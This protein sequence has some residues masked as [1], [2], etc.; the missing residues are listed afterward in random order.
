MYN[1]YPEKTY[2]FLTEKAQAI[3]PTAWQA[4]TEKLTKS[5]K[6]K[7]KQQRSK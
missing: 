7:L 1:V 2:R 3:T 5:E 6:L 4:A